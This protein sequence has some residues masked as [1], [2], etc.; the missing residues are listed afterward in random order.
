MPGW[1]GKS[2][3]KIRLRSP[4]EHETADTLTVWMLGTIPNEHGSEER[5]RRNRLNRE[6]NEQ[7]KE[8]C[9]IY[10][11]NI[12]NAVKKQRT[13]SRCIVLL[14]ITVIMDS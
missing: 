5:E 11:M 8:K 6:T 3:P 1:R 10:T 7:Q 2:R 13:N 12:H 4:V 14:S 9:R